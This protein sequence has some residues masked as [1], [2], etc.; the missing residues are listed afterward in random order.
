[1]AR[2]RPLIDITTA[3]ARYHKGFGQGEGKSYLP[4]VL[5]HHV[6]SRGESS[7][8]L[9]V[10]TNRLH[11]CLSGL[12]TDWLH[13]LEWIRSVRDIREQLPL[14]PYEETIDIAERA[15]FRHP[16]H[17]KS[18]NC[19]VMTS[20]FLV[21][22]EL[23][24]GRLTTHAWALKRAHD[25]ASK[26]T[27]VKL[28]IERRYWRERDVTW[29]IGTDLDLPKTLVANLN[30]IRESRGFASYTTLSQS[31]LRDL[32]A[33]LTRQV[34]DQSETAL[35]HVA[36]DCDR[37]LALEP[38]TSLQMSYYLLATRQWRFDMV[39][40]RIDPTAPLSIRGAALVHDQLALS[41]MGSGSER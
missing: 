24:D 31:D 10:K 7:R 8:D 30:L 9:G 5:V 36:R 13:C 34:F 41:R 16:R 38:G 27:L 25:L 29:N 6:P 15:G 3:P 21:T 40:T 37:R 28:E 19:I 33:V 12:E 22:V 20:D 2:I 1:M 26:A 35:R 39:E 17:P 18:K 32:S 11:H 23:P 4:W 14:W